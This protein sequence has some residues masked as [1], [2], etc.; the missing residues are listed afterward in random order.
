MGKHERGRLQGTLD[1]LVLKTLASQG[2]MHGFGISNFIREG[3]DGVLLVEEGSLYPALHRMTAE[4]VL[5]ARWGTSEFNRRARYYGITERGR[6]Q[7]AAEESNWKEVAGAV[8]RFLRY[9]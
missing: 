9:A 3:S 1:L 8:N 6:K 4:R 5:T 2:A 7:L